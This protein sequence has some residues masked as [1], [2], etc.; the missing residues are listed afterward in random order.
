MSCDLIFGT[1]TS[2]GHLRNYSCYCV[3]VENLK[4]NR[5]NAFFKGRQCLGDA[6]KRQKMYCDRDTAPRHFKKGDWVIYWHKPIAM[7]TLSSDRP[8]IVIRT[9]LRKQRASPK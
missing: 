1:P 5:V 3:Y 8:F 7:Q 9:N 2:R 4:N 6:T